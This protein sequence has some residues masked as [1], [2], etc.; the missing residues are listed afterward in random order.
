MKWLMAFWTLIMT[1]TAWA[2]TDHAMGEGSLHALYH[3]I[4]WTIFAVVV[5]KAVTWF[6]GKNKQE[7]E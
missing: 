1:S 2:H 6:K 5:F 3:A 4:F 7:K